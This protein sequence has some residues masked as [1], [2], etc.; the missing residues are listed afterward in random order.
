MWE[1]YLENDPDRDYIIDGVCHGFKIV[2]T[3]LCNIESYEVDNYL[4]AENMVA[5]PK[6]DDL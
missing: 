3:A 1:Y 4:S 6:L 2:D 5:K